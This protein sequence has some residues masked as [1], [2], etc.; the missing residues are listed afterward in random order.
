[1]VVNASLFMEGTYNL[2]KI[3]ET[4]VVSNPDLFLLNINQALDG[5]LVIALIYAT[6]IVLFLIARQNENVKDTEA[7]SY[8]G[9]IIS[10][11]ALFLLFIKIDG[12]RLVTFLQVFPIWVITGIA[13][14]LDKLN[15]TY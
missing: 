7:L 2:T 4:D 14:L 15:I 8:S 13:I 10:F 6:L 12:A 3:V 11:V 9:V 5:W 1:M